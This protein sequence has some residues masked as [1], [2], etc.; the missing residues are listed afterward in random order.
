[1]CLD[2]VLECQQSSLFQTFFFFFF[3]FTLAKAA[4]SVL[5]CEHI[6]LSSHCSILA[7]LLEIEFRNHIHTKMC[8]CMVLALY[9]LFLC[10]QD[11]VYMTVDS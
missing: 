5:P 1:M 2:L 4:S 8:S 9:E 11:N 3:T 7:W 6:L 10:K